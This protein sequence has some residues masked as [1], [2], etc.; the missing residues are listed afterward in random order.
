MS[1]RDEIS[2]KL[3]NVQGDDRLSIVRRQGLLVLRERFEP[4]RPEADDGC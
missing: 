1:I 4:K 3:E 2:R